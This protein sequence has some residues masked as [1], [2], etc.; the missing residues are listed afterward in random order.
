[1]EHDW[2][3]VYEDCWHRPIESVVWMPIRCDTPH[4]VDE[5]TKSSFYFSGGAVIVFDAG[6]MLFYTWTQRGLAVGSEVEHFGRLTLDRIA[7]INEDPWLLTEN[8][9][10]LRVDL[11]ANHADDRYR[12]VT[13]ARHLLKSSR[14]EGALWVATSD[15]YEVQADG[16]DLWVSMSVDPTNS[17][18][19]VLV[20]SIVPADCTSPA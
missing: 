8:A 9:R 11:F 10:L 2:H 4:V 20:Q 16:D 15:R 3:K 5:R 12:Q 7:A 13:A 17:D 19:L 18:E 14:G 6:P 1:L